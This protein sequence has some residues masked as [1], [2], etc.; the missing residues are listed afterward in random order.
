[1]A[2]LKENGRT[3]A[4]YRPAASQ[5]K[6]CVGVL[7]SAAPLAGTANSTLSEL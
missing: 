1:M 3:F 6:A 4:D 7:F 2:V 5:S